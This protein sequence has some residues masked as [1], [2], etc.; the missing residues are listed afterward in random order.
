MAIALPLFVSPVEL[1][2]GYWCDGGMVDIFPV[3]PIL[4]LEET[5][6]FTLAV[7]G[8][9]PP[10]FAGED[11]SGWQD[12]RGSILYVASQIRTCQQAELAR[13][14][15]ARLRRRSTVAMI[16]PVP[17]DT[18]KGVGFYRQFLNSEQWPQFMRDGR[19]AAR[20]ALYQ[21]G[22]QQLTVARAS[23]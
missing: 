3:H 14:N 8:F 19:L 16:E 10:G 2:G 23:A 13:V 1:D 11:A 9:Y 5:P 7:N 22:A 6:E 20:R 17:Y 18:V 12:R 15:L 4:E 21:L